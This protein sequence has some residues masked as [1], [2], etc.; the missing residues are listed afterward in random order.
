M[1]R[2]ESAGTTPRNLGVRRHGM[3]DTLLHEVHA[4]PFESLA[5]PLHISHMSFLSGTRAQETEHRHVDELCRR[6]GIDGPAAGCDHFVAQAGDFR[7]RWERHTEFSTYTIFRGGEPSE[8]FSVNPCDAI[9]RDWLDAL[10]G[11]LLAACHLTVLRSEAVGEGAERMGEYFDPD[12]LAGSR[13]AGGAATVWTDFRVGED[14]FTRLLVLDRGLRPAQAGRLVRRLLEI[15]TYRLAALLGL[16]LARRISPEITEMEAQLGDL[17]D[18]LASVSDLAQERELLGKLSDLSA[19]VE[20]LMAR[21]NFR[22]GATKAYG[23]IVRRRIHALREDRIEGVSTIDEFMERRLAPA[24]DTCDYVLDRLDR[25]SK[26]LSR[27][28]NLL[29]TRVDV[30]LEAQNRDLLESMNR[31]AR[32]QLRLQ[33]TVEGLSVV[34]LSYYSV[35]LVGYAAKGLK[36]AGVSVPVDLVVGASIPVVAL[37]VAAGVWS[38]RRRVQKAD[39]HGE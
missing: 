6:L 14:G 5:G 19:R 36:A 2:S 18:H 20:R 27:A 16:P 28:A 4:R 23:A 10:P 35:S 32:L 15:E 37:A 30:A 11:E 33:E 29:R 22:F 17:T 1:N 26:R 21:T 39:G 25:L 38:V 13:C 12:S 34:I 7:L 24:M 9:P 8:P 3:R 31:R